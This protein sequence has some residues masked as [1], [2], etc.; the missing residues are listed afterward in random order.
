MEL[1]LYFATLLTK[2]L[3]L[4]MGLFLLTR[5]RLKPAPVALIGLAAG[6][7]FVG[8]L[9][10]FHALLGFDYHIFWQA[11]RDVWLGRDPYAAESFAD[12][13]FLNPPTALPLFA[14][15][16]LV[17]FEVSFAVWT[18]ANALACLALVAWTQWT[19]LA[20]ERLDSRQS[21]PPWALPPLALAAL[22]AILLVSDACLTTFYLGQLSILAA[23]LLLA[24]LGAQACGRP[25]WAGVALALATVKV[26]TMLPFLL[27]FLRKV[28][29]WTWL[30]LAAGVLGLCLVTGSPAELPG[31]LATLRERIGQL[32]APGVVNDYSFAG[33]RSDNLLGFDH[34]LY[35]LGLRDRGLIRAGQ[36]L[37][38]A[39]LGAWVAYQVRPGG[40][41]PRA[42]A[43]SL[44]ALFAM[45]FFYHRGYDAPL[46]V[47]PL[48]YSTGRARMTHGRA[49][50]LFAACAVAVLLVLF[51]NIEF[52][53][54]VREA[55][56]GGGVWGRL[57]QAVVLPYGT[58]C[59]LAA[60]F[61]L[62]RG[63]R[64][65]MDKE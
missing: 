43:C 12:L 13:P 1:D 51:L 6:I 58:W 37:A 21:P 19:L 11:G 56:F 52:L 62:V 31:R 7:L 55:S 45:V 46:L 28:D 16:A 42:A 50:L 9:L 17:P 5:T 49:R 54:V 61:C 48:V 4:G 33:P 35:R 26:G 8:V 14:L 10:R 44:I 20:Q 38:L 63:A 25:G 15:F 47:L 30:T 22:T 23:C 18:V 36:Y 32:E 2:A 59:V 41:L 57:A 65:R 29:R 27:L 64:C 3:A 24:A 39:V 60:M 40:D 34:A 53:G